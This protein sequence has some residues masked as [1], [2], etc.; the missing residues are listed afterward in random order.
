[1]RTRLAL[2]LCLAVQS[3]ACK[4]E[5]PAEPEL[6]LPRVRVVP[7]QK[8]P[9]ERTLRVAGEL[10]APPGRE[11]KLTP[12]VPGRLVL[13]RVAEG[14]AV[15]TG[16]VLA[17]VEPGPVSAELQQAEATA[18]EAAAAARAAE[19][20]RARTEVLVQHGVAARQEAEQDQ[21]AEA[22]AV[23]A[24]QRARAA[25]DVAR[26]NVG[27]SQLQAPFDGIVTAVFIRQGET[28]DGTAQPVLQVS[29]VD[30]LELRAF[31][32]QEDAA[33][34]HAGMRASLSVE[35]QEET[36]PGEVI[37]VSPAID[38]RSG[39]VLVRLRFP[40]PKGA[41]RLGAFGRAG[42]VLA[43]EGTAFPLPA[44]ALLPR[45]DGGLGVAVVQDGK[46]KSVPVTV[47]SEEGGRAVVQGPLQDGEEV[48]VE[49]GYSLPEGA[50]VEVVR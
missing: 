12:L 30:P 7:A 44:S 19:A 25:V 21:S 5:P 18:R 3:M 16:Q 43:E 24:E 23:A 27:R 39:N 2:L 33:R 41:L 47:W 42:I 50:G 37:A 46:V 26:R 1:M 49:G 20:K 36:S 17:E 45:G 6:P 29:A 28:V 11:V 4:Q 10:S 14:D 15:R 34:V 38:P 40:N 22:A 48:I 31:V 9:A 8:G 13:L 35:G 32:P